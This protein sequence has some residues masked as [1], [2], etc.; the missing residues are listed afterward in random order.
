MH[1]S[2]HV[3]A[4]AVMVIETMAKAHG[5][6]QATAKGWGKAT[7]QVQVKAVGKER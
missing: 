4:V 5:E 1:K 3:T 6:I 2:P 7:G